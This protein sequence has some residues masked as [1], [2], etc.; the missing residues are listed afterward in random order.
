M[1]MH[2]P[3]FNPEALQVLD[4]IHADSGRVHADVRWRRTGKPRAP[5][6]RSE[7]RAVMDTRDVTRKVV[8]D[9]AREIQRRERRAGRREAVHS[10]FKLRRDI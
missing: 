1:G 10:A 9:R 5:D 3:A 8:P 6:V 7:P 2:P 4:D